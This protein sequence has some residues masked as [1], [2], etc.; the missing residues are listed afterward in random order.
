[1]PIHLG[2]WSSVLFWGPALV[3]IGLVLASMPLTVVGTLKKRRWILSLGIR[4]GL[5]GVGLNL[6]WIG[7]VGLVFSAPVLLV[8]LTS[9]QWLG[10]FFLPILWLL[11]V[12]SIAGGVKT[13]QW[14]VRRDRDPL[15]QWGTGNRIPDDWK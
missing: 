7:V 6:T 5:A 15:T 1:M 9:G 12:G 2:A 10:L 11:G 8:F 13:L 3:G 14:A 4:A